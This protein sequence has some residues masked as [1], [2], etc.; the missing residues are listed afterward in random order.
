[1]SHSCGGTDQT[2]RLSWA[3][4]VASPLSWKGRSCAPSQSELAEDL[5]LPSSIS[6][7]KEVRMGRPNNED[8][9]TRVQDRYNLSVPTVLL[10]A[11]GSPTVPQ[12]QR[13]TLTEL[14]SGAKGR[15][16]ES[17]QAHQLQVLQGIALSF[18]QYNAVWSFCCPGKGRSFMG[19]RSTS[20]PCP[21]SKHAYRFATGVLF[22][23]GHRSPLCHG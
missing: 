6:T 13:D 3:I 17:C 14:A 19:A 7:P 23:L 15:R 10:R 4:S 12:N 22:C 5:S 9:V 21:W 2:V 20:H 16:F 1:M 11:F 18:D 8:T